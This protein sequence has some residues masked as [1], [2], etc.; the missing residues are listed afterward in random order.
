MQDLAA[1]INYAGWISMLIIAFLL[2]FI[3]PVDCFQ[4]SNLFLYNFT[5]KQDT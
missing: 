4:N 1:Y 3:T 5:K 2:L